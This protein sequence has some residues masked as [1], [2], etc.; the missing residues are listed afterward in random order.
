MRLNRP[1]GK[2]AVLI[3]ALVPLLTGHQLV[4]PQSPPVL[5]IARFSAEKADGSLPVNWE[6]FY[7]KNIERHT[8]HRLV[9]M[10]GQVVVKATA[11][12]SVSR[13]TGP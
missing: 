12:G 1:S 10:D 3:V 5:E 11:D 2:A 8:D 4:S 13:L 7:V 9:V 6:P